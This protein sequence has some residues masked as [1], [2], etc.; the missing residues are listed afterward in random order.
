M[1]TDA[2]VTSWRVLAAAVSAGRLTTLIDVC[3]L[4]VQ[5]AEA[6][7][8][9]HAAVRPHRVHTLL[10]RTQQ[11]VL[12]LVHICAGVSSELVSAVTDAPEAAGGVL[13]AAVGAT[14][15]VCTLVCV[16]AGRVERVGLVSAVTHAAV[17]P[18]WLIHTQAPPTHTWPGLTRCTADSRGPCGGRT[19]R[20]RGRGTFGRRGN[21]ALCGRGGERAPGPRRSDS[22]N[23]LLGA[24]T[25]MAASLIRSGPWFGIT[26]SV[27][28]L[29]R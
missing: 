16:V 6:R 24:R 26:G 15:A 23:R 2:A 7:A 25:R 17:P 9:G 5:Q 12:A 14:G 22:A 1:A 8:A 13:T 19:L 10:T 18:H 27:R 4:A 21:G 20:C 3:T 11:R 28:G 29:R